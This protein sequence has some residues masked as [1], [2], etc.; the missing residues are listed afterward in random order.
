MK[1]LITTFILGIFSL[2]IFATSSKTI[3]QGDFNFTYQWEDSSNTCTITNITIAN[4]TP[5]ILTIPKVLLNNTQEELQV[6]NISTTTYCIDALNS[7]DTLIFESGF[8]I[9]V[10]EKIQASNAHPEFYSTHVTTVTLPNNIAQFDIQSVY[11]VFPNCSSIAFQTGTTIKS[12]S[13]T[14]TAN[15]IHLLSF[16]IPNSVETIESYTF[17]HFPYI[18][19]ITFQDNSSIHTIQE[20]AFGQCQN[21]QTITL[22]ESIQVLGDKVFHQCLN[23]NQVTFDLPS[24]LKTIGDSCFYASGIKSLHFPNSIDTIF[25]HSLVQNSTNF[26]IKIESN[27]VLYVDHD[28]NISQLCLRGDDTQSPL[29]DYDQTHSITLNNG[30]QFEMIIPNSQRWYQIALPYACN[31]WN[32][33][34]YNEETHET[35]KNLNSTYN[36][37]W[38]YKLFVGNTLAENNGRTITPTWRIPIQKNTKLPVQLGFAFRSLVTR[39]PIILS[40]NMSQVQTLNNNI[41]QNM[42]LIYTFIN[43]GDL[44]FQNWGF[45]GN[46]LLNTLGKNGYYQISSTTEM[47][48]NDPIVAVQ[49]T[50]HP[51]NYIQKPVSEIT[52]HPFQA[53]FTQINHNQRMGVINFSTLPLN[54]TNGVNQNCDDYIELE[55][56][57]ASQQIANTSLR[58]DNQFTNS[59][60]HGYD[61]IKFK[62]HY[63]QVLGI[64]TQ[65]IQ[66]DLVYNALPTSDCTSIP[67]IVNCNTIGNYTISIKNTSH[68][69]NITALYLIDRT[70]QSV[71]NLR[72]Q[73]YSFNSGIFNYKKRFVLSTQPNFQPTNTENTTLNIPI[74]SEKN[75]I[76]IQSVPKNAIISIISTTGKTLISSKQ[77]STEFRSIPLESGLYLI[78]IQSDSSNSI[79]K[80]LIP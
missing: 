60:E 30:L 38:T 9:N 78:K 13:N 1:K 18:A 62:N 73:D 23:L 59:Y 48:D 15:N 8:A 49:D 4:G 58:I 77:I 67:L 46:S 22:P 36:R 6:T 37:Y 75:Q 80:I 40:F 28:I 53:F 16:E 61:I 17:K 32:V 51:G 63:P 41:S 72:I 29:I 39:H 50:Q 2:I 34:T 68:F 71:V 10:L 5:N 20:E 26:T 19:H 33:Y 7:V 76:C 11:S 24:S 66:E 54:N 47:A 74:W 65:S 52:I 42:S 45:F 56:K 79:N 55:I 12:I 57:N 43:N 21:I 3:Q 35:G 25:T 44:A 70:T 14:S 27:T 64:Y 69:T 31:D